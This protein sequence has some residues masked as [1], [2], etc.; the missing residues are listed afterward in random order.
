MTVTTCSTAAATRQSSPGTQSLRFKFDTRFLC[1]FQVPQMQSRDI[2]PA[3]SK[4]TKSEKQ[5]VAW[6]KRLMKSFC[7]KRHTHQR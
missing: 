5:V 2:N 1:T 3:S 6:A 4:L 7:N